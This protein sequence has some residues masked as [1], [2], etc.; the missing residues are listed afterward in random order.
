M[1]GHFAAGIA[2]AGTEASTDHCTCAYDIEGS[3][4]RPRGVFFLSVARVM[5]VAFV[6][7]VSI[8]FKVVKNFVV[9]SYIFEWSFE[10]YAVLCLFVCLLLHVLV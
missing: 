3:S 8:L 6:L 2:R 4:E 5:S 7:V 9:F 10:Y 1:A